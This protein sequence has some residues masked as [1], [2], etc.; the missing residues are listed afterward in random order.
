MELTNIQLFDT[1]DWSCEME[2]YVFG[3]LRGSTHKK[4]LRLNVI[5]KIY[6]SSTV[7]YTPNEVTDTTLLTTTATT[8][9]SVLEEDV[10]HGPEKSYGNASIT[11]AAITTPKSQINNDSMGKYNCI[12]LSQV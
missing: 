3:S 2:K 7:I 11:T 10:D 6:P 4:I 9:S 8:T 12:I 5:P 1:G